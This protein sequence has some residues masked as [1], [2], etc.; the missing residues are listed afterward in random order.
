MAAYFFDSSALVKRYVIERGSTWVI[1]IT[2]PAVGNSIPGNLAVPHTPT[3]ESIRRLKAQV[4]S[5]RL[6]PVFSPLEWT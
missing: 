4:G 6:K 2:T 3:C 5:N 1:R